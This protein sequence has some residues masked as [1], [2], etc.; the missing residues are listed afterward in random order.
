MRIYL[1]FNSFWGVINKFWQI[2]FEAFFCN[3]VFNFE[4]VKKD[5]FKTGS[6]ASVLMPHNLLHC[7]AQKCD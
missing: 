3:F 2:I 6:P 4:C 7:Q 5:L 1:I